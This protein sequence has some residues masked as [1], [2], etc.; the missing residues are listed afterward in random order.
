[1]SKAPDDA[2]DDLEAVR[3]I[4]EALKPFKTEEQDRIIRWAKEKLGLPS[5]S[6]A[7]PHEKP[8]VS[9]AP[10]HP[11]QHKKH[12]D[13]KTFVSE[14][15]PSNDAHFAATVAY[16]FQFEAPESERKDS[17]SGND[18]QEA[19]RKV[20]RERLRNQG[21]TLRNAHKL[22][23]F[24]KAS[25]KGYFSINTVGENLVAMTLPGNVTQKP[26]S[27]KPKNTKPKASK[28]AKLK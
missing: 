25:E 4:T 9:S 7:P 13:I 16:Y 22:G 5:S 11:T 20:G 6:Q 1:M 28:K 3:R 23:Y 24:D 8:E 10:S 15:N 12:L 21:Q 18:L 26:T 2:P 14:K 27:R 17:I 19:C